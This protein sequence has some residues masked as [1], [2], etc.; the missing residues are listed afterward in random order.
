MTF[1]KTL[2]G[3]EFSFQTHEWMDGWK[4]RQIWKL[5]YL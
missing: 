3:I 4:D 5:K 2:A 1:C